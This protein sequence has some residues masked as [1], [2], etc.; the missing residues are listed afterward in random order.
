MRHSIPR[1]FCYSFVSGEHEL[2]VLRPQK[3]VNFHRPEKVV[4][5]LQQTVI[6]ESTSQADTYEYHQY[7]K[8]NLSSV[9]KMTEGINVNRGIFKKQLCRF[10]FRSGFSPGG[11][12]NLT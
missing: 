3:Q 1:N 12:V 5:S 11:R 6:N 10:H 9:T 4:V 2:C 8:G 7:L